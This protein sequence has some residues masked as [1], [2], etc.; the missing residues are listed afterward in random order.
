MVDSIHKEQTGISKKE[1][2]Q[3]I[4]DGFV[5]ERRGEDPRQ[6]WY[7]IDWVIA[8]LNEGEQGEFRRLEGERWE[9]LT[10]VKRAEV[11]GGRVGSIMEFF[12]KGRS[13]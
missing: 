4:R 5:K 13:A 3:W 7:A 1:M 2:E 9:Q 6:R 10:P 8:Q 12:G 11:K